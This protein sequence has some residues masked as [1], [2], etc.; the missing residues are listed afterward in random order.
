[1][2]L[3][4]LAIGFAACFLLLGYVRYS[5]SYDANVPQAETIYMAKGRGNFGG[6][7]PWF[8]GS[9][10]PFLEVGQRSGLV[11]ASTLMEPLFRAMKIGA[12]IT[13]D[14]K[15]YAVHP[16][17][18]TMFALKPLEGDLTAAL[19]RPD[20]LALTESQARILFG[21]SHVVGRSVTIGKLSF[22]VAA[23]LADPPSN[24]TLNY[25]A[26]TGITSAVWEDKSREEEFQDWGSSQGGKL[27]F[28]LKPGASPT[29]LA[30]VLQAASV[31]SP[32]NS[33]LP[34]ELIRELGN[35]PLL[36]IKLVRLTDLYFDTDLANKFNNSQHGDLRTVAGLAIVAVLILLLAMANYVNLATV[37]TLARQ[38]EIAMRKVLGASAS[39][40]TRQLFAESLLV[41]L[42]STLLGVL[43]AW[44]LLPGFSALMDRK[45][46]G[47]FSLENLLLGLAL[48]TVVGLATGGYPAWM[49]H[50][51]QPQRALTGRGN[52]E[53]I[54]TVNLRRLLTIA[55]FSAAMALTGIT[56]AIAWQTHFASHVDPGINLSPL[57]VLDLPPESNGDSRGLRESLARIPGVEGVAGTLNLVP[58][59]SYENNA[60]TVSRSSGQ[61]AEMPV[62]KVNVNFFDVLGLPALAGRVFD[63]K[64]DGEKNVNVVVLSA[65]AVHE[66]GYISPQAALDQIVTIGAGADARTVRVV[67]VIPDIRYVSLR[68]MP[69]PI[70]YIPDPATN[71][72]TLRSSGDRTKLEQAIETLQRQY[73]PNDAVNVRRMESYFT[74][75]YSEDL[76]LAKLLGLASVIAIAIAAFGIY[77]L[78]AYSVQRLTKQIVLRK[79]FGANRSA[80]GK[81]VGREFIA[82][83]AIGAL[84]GL[85]I[86]AWAIQSYLAS[87]VEH[88]PIGAWTLLAAI[89][90]A[91]LV[92]L[93]STLR[94]TSIAMRISPA[95]ALRD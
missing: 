5:L 18:A 33:Q 58:G 66:L 12:K 43:L 55:Q 1:V 59:R 93:I 23:L 19:T 27:Y 57:L 90:I 67:G 11:D 34:P 61:K 72:L 15:L 86:A 41:A 71:I 78:S 20:M 37:R 56:L 77:V 53:T 74:E 73:F 52:S 84:I 51:V 10:L 13:H 36:D 22:T 79:L 81:L 46:E 49:A 48:G 25:A 92:T 68:N 16:S 35:K 4:G 87:F 44:L 80:I 69:K 45:L 47:L 94:H 62:A 39:R 50:R 42:A 85:P 24:S 7:T 28:K 82:V 54:G 9:P 60:T 21:A 40:L 32:I 63:L 17:F 75:N 14:V 31:H 83:I 65:K 29:A 2:V 30:Q 64:I 3:L 89:F 88:A 91:I 26:L 6:G 38:R 8:E 76:R 95:Q 70:V